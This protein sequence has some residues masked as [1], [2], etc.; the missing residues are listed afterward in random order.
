MEVFVEDE[1]ISLDL[2]QDEIE[3]LQELAQEIIYDEADCRRALHKLLG[4]DEE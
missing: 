2:Y 1:E 4:M 3:R